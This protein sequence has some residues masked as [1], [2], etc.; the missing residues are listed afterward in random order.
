MSDK[1]MSDKSDRFVRGNERLNRMLADPDTAQ[2]VQ[3]IRDEMAQADR[4]HRSSLAAIR[5][6]VG[7]TQ[8]DLAERM[9]VKQSAISGLERRPDV[10]LSTLAGYLVAAGGSNIRVMVTLNGADIEYPIDTEALTD[11]KA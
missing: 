3:T 11:Q 8:V 6:A 9:G 4:D 7:L 1:R 10:L 5:R 2:S